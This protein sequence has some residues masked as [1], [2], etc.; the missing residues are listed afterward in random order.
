MAKYATNVS[1]AILLPS[2]IQVTESI[3]GSVVPL[4]MFFEIVNI[5][6]Q[7]H[8]L[9]YDHD[10]GHH[11]CLLQ[12]YRMAE[13]HGLGLFMAIIFLSGEMAGVR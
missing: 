8:H 5:C 7:Y 6:H 13:G 9:D 2:S 10:D 4:A 11:L 1:G 3:S 12:Q